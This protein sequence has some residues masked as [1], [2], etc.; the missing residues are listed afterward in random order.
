[1]LLRISI[2]S[3]QLI[4]TCFPFQP[5][6]QFPPQ[7]STSPHINTII[8]APNDDT[9]FVGATNN[10]FVL[11]GNL[12]LLHRHKTGPLWDHP[13]CVLGPSNGS[14]C[15]SYK[16][17]NLSTTVLVDNKNLALLLDPTDDRTLIVCGSHRNG[18]C[19]FHSAGDLQEIHE[20]NKHHL[21]NIPERFSVSN[22][23]TVL[24]AGPGPEE[25][26]SFVWMGAFK[27]LNEEDKYDSFRGNLG[28][29]ARSFGVKGGKVFFSPIR[30]KVALTCNYNI[31]FV[32]AFESSGFSYFLANM[33]AVVPSVTFFSKNCFFNTRTLSSKVIQICQTD[34]TLRSHVET[35]LTCTLDKSDWNILR[36]AT[37][38]TPSKTLLGTY[39]SSK[40][41][42]RSEVDIRPGEQFIAAVLASEV[43]SSQQ[44]LCLY[45][46]SWIRNTMLRNL[47]RCFNQSLGET[48]PQ[49]PNSVKCKTLN[50]VVKDNYCRRDGC[51][52]M[53]GPLSGII[54]IDST[55]S[56]IINREDDVTAMTSLVVDSFNASHTLLFLGTKAGKLM[57]VLLETFNNSHA[58]RLYKT[59]ELSPSDNTAVHK[60]I[61]PSKDSRFLFASTEEKVYKIPVSECDEL[62]SCKTCLSSP[63][64]L[65]GWC[66]LENRCSPKSSCLSDGFQG[67]W[68]KSQGSNPDLSSCPFIGSVTPYVI[69]WD[70]DIENITFNVKNLPTASNGESSLKCSFLVDGVFSPVKVPATQSE[71]GQLTCNLID[72][73]RILPDKIEERKLEVRIFAIDEGSARKPL[74]STEFLVVTCPSIKN[75]SSCLGSNPACGWCFTSNRCT[76]TTRCPN[77]AEEPLRN[78]KKCPRILPQI[79]TDASAGFHKILEIK[80]KN[81]PEKSYRGTRLE[82]FC[83]VH[84]SSEELLATYVSNSSIKCH[85]KPFK[86][87]GN[88]PNSTSA[89]IFWRDRNIVF[90]IENVF[91]ITVFNCSSMSQDGDCSICKSM[92][93]AKERKKSFGC[94]WC[95]GS[96]RHSCREEH[97]CPDPRI[98]EVTPLSGPM[99]GG[100]VIT[101]RGSHLGLRRNITIGDIECSN[102]GSEIS[103]KITCRTNPSPKSSGY[104]PLK[105]QVDD[106]QATLSPFTFAYLNPLVHSIHPSFG[107]VSGG[108]VVTI[109]GRD[110]TFDEEHDFHVVVGSTCVLDETVSNSSA[111]VCKRNPMVVYPTSLPLEIPVEVKIDSAKVS[112]EKVSFVVR[113]DPVVFDL[114]PQSIRMSDGC[115]IRVRGINLNSSSSPSIKLSSEDSS[116]KPTFFNDTFME[117]SF[118]L[119]QPDKVDLTFIFDGVQISRSFEVQED[120]SIHRF[121]RSFHKNKH[122][123]ELQG[124]GFLSE[125]RSG[126][127]KI[128]VGEVVCNITELTDSIISCLLPYNVSDDG[129]IQ[130]NVTLGN[131]ELSTG[132]LHPF[133]TRPTFSKVD[134]RVPIVVGSIVGGFLILVFTGVV[135]MLRKISTTRKRNNL[136]IKRIQVLEKTISVQC[137][138]SFAE[139]Q[140]HVSGFSSEI[141]EAGIPYWDF[142]TYAFKFLFPM[143]KDHEVL[144]PPGNKINIDR[145]ERLV[146]LHQ[147]LSSKSF[148]LTF[149]RTLEGHPKEFGIEDRSKIASW[150]TVIF[151]DKLEYLTIVMK[152]L[153]E[154]LIRKSLERNTQKMMLRRTESV[155][156]KLMTNWLCLTMY[157]H[158]KDEVGGCLFKLCKAIEYQVDDGPVDAVTQESKFSLAEERLLRVKVDPQPLN[159]TVV[160]TEPGYS[161]PVSCKLIDCDTISQAKC[162]AMKALYKNRPYSSIP[163]PDQF[164]LRLLVAGRENGVVLKDEDSTSSRSHEWVQLNTLK[165]FNVKTGSTLLLTFQQKNHFEHDNAAVW[166][167]HETVLFESGSNWGTLKQSEVKSEPKQFHLVKQ[168]ELHSHY[169]GSEKL[170]SEVFL[171]RLLITKKA[172]E[173]YI[174]RLFEALMASDCNLPPTIKFLFDFFDTT[175]HKYNIVDADVVHIWK[176][177]SLPLRFWVSVLRNPDFVFDVEKSSL[178]DPC[179]AVIAQVFIDGCSTHKQ[180]LGLDSSSAKLLFANE[181]QNYKTQMN[182]FYASIQR[183]PPVDRNSLNHFL[184]IVENEAENKFNIQVALHEVLIYV[185]KFKNEIQE[186]LDED[187]TCCSLK[188]PVKFHQMFS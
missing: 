51:D 70:S 21:A 23:S 99:Q 6:A 79:E 127:V 179:L 37:L 85:L 88:E 53:E 66:S 122:L 112:N 3:L 152:E 19:R 9:I 126:G 107:P 184:H 84:G 103:T 36:A 134:T 174:K 45:P 182:G 30:D 137:K 171:P 86:W 26:R 133:N 72:L 10:I 35:P 75:C 119:L 28:I 166:R 11:D 156:E 183:M 46:L 2:F 150:L 186:A 14:R 87:A 132:S 154:E 56:L 130:I 25:G 165:H 101:L 124:E 38:I 181:M 153:L 77:M 81:L 59:V 158:I 160:G 157:H 62:L 169:E 105:I 185:T 80:A 92:N 162:K 57:K 64:P 187:L 161:G 34:S 27:R 5:D 180:Q 145:N 94:K 22:D 67:V 39:S 178:V 139:L 97:E 71:F 125:C 90:P 151:I 4:C 118:P 111:I 113:G 48:G 188:L 42:Q 155:V 31:E 144:R 17:T 168:D 89:Q 116:I 18:L 12:S 52:E 83:K 141:S 129:D 68:L 123:I 104:S 61:F 175:A 177:N 63:D 13:D 136:L 76:K 135:I 173:D 102:V 159:V 138:Q 96:C 147:L 47:R 55:P 1:M 117:F 167:S 148:L 58:N 100:T 50:A 69:N 121:S 110:L 98:E 170:M 60:N 120:P 54:R 78:V 65:C 108:T 40:L 95:E 109:F 163:L 115:P 41:K 172:L 32:S 128:T 20:N 146:H 164:E 140:T 49:F 114:N 33:P 91:K 149:I 15:I 143:L 82:Y 43:W 7:N 176:S 16:G 74:Q 24:F 73:R 106:R 131:L 93:L 29:S 142:Q 8:S 44:V